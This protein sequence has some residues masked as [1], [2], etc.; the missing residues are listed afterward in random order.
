[1]S[2]RNW[3]ISTLSFLLLIGG[4]IV[5]AN[6]AFDIF[7]QFRPVRGRHLPVYGDE[8]TAKYLLS[9]KY[10]PENFNALLV[11]ASITANW[12]VHEFDQ[13]RV[14]NASLNGGNFVEE[15]ALIEAALDRPGIECVLLLVHPA[16]TVDHE[17]RTV[18]MTP[19]LRRAA[20]G[21]M[22]LWDAY[23]QMLNERLG[24]LAKGIDDAGVADFGSKRREMNPKMQAMWNASSFPID[25]LAVQAYRAVVADLKARDIGVVFIVAP[26]A[27]TL[28]RAKGA[29]LDAYYE[30]MRADLG[31]DG[32]WIDFHSADYEKFAG[33]PENFTDGV[34]LTPKGA[35]QLVS[36]ANRHIGTWITDRRLR[37][38]SS[39]PS[40]SAARSR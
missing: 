9:W 29:M 12:N 22:A 36:E 40:N 37:L 26:T 2:A 38:R 19:E 27:D 23:K 4:V 28:V 30:R 16:L 39:A 35:T 6:V 1:M 20:L 17:F 24:R 8:R 21:S 25:S 5:G 3:L 15:R 18:E 32:L 31:S 34:H 10:V 14:Y 33:N 11:G 13:L 7:G